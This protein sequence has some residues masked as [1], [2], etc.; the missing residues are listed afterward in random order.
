MVHV[1][2]RYVLQNGMCYKS[3]RVTKRY[4]LQIGTC[5]KTIRV[6]KRYVLQNGTCH[7]MV[8]V[9]KRYVSQNKRYV[10]KRFILLNGTFL[11]CPM[12]AL[13]HGLAGHLSKRKLTLDIVSQTQH[14]STNPW[15]SWAFVLT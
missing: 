6:T 15:I 10:T 14:N 13:T 5:Y 4:V 1:T 7:K 8:H 11:H 2:K 3:V 9:T 12:N